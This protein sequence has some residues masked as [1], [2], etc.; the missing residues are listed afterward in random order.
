MYV[1]WALKKPAVFSQSAVEKE[2]LLAVF[3]DASFAT[4][5]LHSSNPQP[6]IR[7][8]G[9]AA[10]PLVSQVKYISHQQL[11]YLIII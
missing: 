11:I 2:Q 8:K 5:R 6:L 3:D 1:T 4:F 10:V 9:G 7:V